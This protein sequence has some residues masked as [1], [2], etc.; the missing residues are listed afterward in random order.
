MF[1]APPDYAQAF[2]KSA[3]KVLAAYEAK[4]P[5]FKKVLQSQRKFAALVVP[6]TRETA[7]LTQLIAGAVEE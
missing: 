3:K 5:F 7:K 4:E 1:D 2:I 6:F